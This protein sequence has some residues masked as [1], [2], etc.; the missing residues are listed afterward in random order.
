MG[1]SGSRSTQL[2]N[3]SGIWD[4]TCK[5]VTTNPVESVV[6]RL[7]WC[8]EEREHWSW[9]PLSSTPRLS[10]SLIWITAKSFFFLMKNCF[11]LYSVCRALFG[12]SQH[13]QHAYWLADLFIKGFYCL[14]ASIC[15][16]MFTL[17]PSLSSFLPKLTYTDHSNRPPLALQL[18]VGGGYWT[19]Q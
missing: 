18:P 17:H 4:L 7:P 6:P 10:S 2:C 9:I 13:S 5:V 1:Y 14:T 16:H 15:H 3:T 11:L 8:N 12:I 19:P